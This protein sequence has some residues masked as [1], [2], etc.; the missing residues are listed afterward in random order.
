MLRMLCPRRFCLYRFLYIFLQRF[1]ARPS[2]QTARPADGKR[3]SEADVGP[4]FASVM[5]DAGLE[6]CDACDFELDTGEAGS[7]EGGNGGPVDDGD[8]VFGVEGG[9]EVVGD[10]IANRAR[11]KDVDVHVVGR[12]ERDVAESATVAGR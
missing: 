5:K 10:E 9:A 8:G 11:A 2:R 6:T 1:H 4:K 3:F 7:G 12:M